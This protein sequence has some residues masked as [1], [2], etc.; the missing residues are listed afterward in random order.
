MNRDQ[1]LS[2][3]VKPHLGDVGIAIEVGVYKGQYSA[4]IVK[5]LTPKKFYGVDPYILFEDYTNPPTDSAYA[6]QANLDNLCVSVQNKFKTFSSESVLIKDTGVNAATQFEDG[7]LDF[8]YIDGD[9][10]YEFVSG[11]IKAWWPKIKSGGIISGH[12]YI[13]EHHV[14][15]I[16]FGVI[17]AVDEFTEK[18]GLKVSLTSEQY[19]SWWVIKP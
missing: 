6:Q 19:A 16:P 13:A 12:D 1:W 11:D 4:A 5:A 14:R 15:K 8:V 17:Q 9:H 18:E 3:V 2:Q 7:S 10:T